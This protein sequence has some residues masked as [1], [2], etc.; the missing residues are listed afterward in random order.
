MDPAAPG[1]LRVTAFLPA[2]WCFAAVYLMPALLCNPL[3]PILLT[4]PGYT[5]A[6]CTGTHC[7]H[8]LQADLMICKNPVGATLFA[9]HQQLSPLS[10]FAHQG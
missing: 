5:P 7:F 3:R 8:V 9:I 1:F 2:A 10:R 6:I 4:R